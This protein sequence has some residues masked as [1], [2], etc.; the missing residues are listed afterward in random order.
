MKLSQQL[1]SAGLGGGLGGELGGGL[2]GGL[3][4]GGWLGSLSGGLGGG[5]RGLSSVGGGPCL[6]STPGNSFGDAQKQ[7]FVW[8]PALHQRFEAA[9]AELGLEQAKPQA[10]AQLMDLHGEN[11]PT[12]QNIKSHLQKYRLHMQKKSEAAARKGAEGKAAA[13]DAGGGGGAIVG[14]GGGGHQAPPKC[15]SDLNL[16]ALRGHDLPDLSLGSFERPSAKR[17]RSDQAEAETAAAAAA[18]AGMLL[19]GNAGSDAS[20]GGGSASGVAVATGSAEPPRQPTQASRV[21]VGTRRAGSA[22]G[23][24]LSALRRLGSA[25][26]AACRLQ[27]EQWRLG[28]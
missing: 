25:A 3:G 8:S 12:R 1:R 15:G 28:A 4:S 22:V 19:L 24:A 26:Q 13:A 2:G 11:A 16:M 10:I 14:G 6:S 20:S 23:G 27:P 17:A 9:V 7:R 18:A 5:F 21:A